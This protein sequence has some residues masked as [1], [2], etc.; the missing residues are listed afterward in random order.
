MHIVL[1]DGTDPKAQALVFP[2]ALDWRT[3]NITHF[4]YWTKALDWS[5]PGFLKI[6]PLQKS[7][8]APGTTPGPTALWIPTSVVLGVLQVSDDHQTPHPAPTMKH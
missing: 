5:T 8:L 3:L 2:Q 4:S 1:I 7:E 6:E